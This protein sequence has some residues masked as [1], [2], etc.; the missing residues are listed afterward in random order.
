MVK[1]PEREIGVAYS[2]CEVR[3][4]V[5]DDDYD[6]RQERKKRRKL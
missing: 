4:Y 2:R 3:G 5:F 6:G 1:K